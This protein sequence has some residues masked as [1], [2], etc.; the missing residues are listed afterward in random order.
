MAYNDINVLTFM[1]TY[2]LA[3]TYHYRLSYN[4]INCYHSDFNVFML[5]SRYFLLLRSHR[6]GQNPYSHFH[7]P[8]NV[9]GRAPFQRDLRGSRYPLP[10]LA[11]KLRP[12]TFGGKRGQDDERDDE[13]FE[14]IHAATV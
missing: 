4:D 2:Q 7:F 1:M 14:W 11:A 5:L 10:R 6:D 13:D 12:I 9:F 3:V 8:R